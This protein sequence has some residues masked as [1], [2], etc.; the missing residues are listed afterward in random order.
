MPQ[1]LS[2]GHRVARKEHRCG[3]CNGPIAVGERH[4]VSTNIFDGRIYDWR[5]CEPCRQ[6]RVLTYVYDWASW[7]DEGVGYDSAIEWS[8]DAHHSTD[9]AERA[10]ARA[11]R[12]RAGLTPATTEETS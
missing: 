1:Q 10:A 7:P 2:A 11:F 12:A 5:T 4:H 9:E 8:D 3:V 6:D